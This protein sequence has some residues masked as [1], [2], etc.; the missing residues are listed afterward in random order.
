MDLTLSIIATI[1]VGFSLFTVV[2]LV[3]GTKGFTMRVPSGP[4]A[5]G[6]II[7]FILNLL[8]W[9][10]TLVAARGWWLGG[11]GWRGSSRPGRWPAFLC[12]SSRPR[13]RS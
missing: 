8:G 13:W 4:D 3:G 12:C 9:I 5:M 10:L 2:A 1:A 6:I 11:A 7:F